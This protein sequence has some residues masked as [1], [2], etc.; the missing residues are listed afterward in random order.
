[1]KPLNMRHLGGIESV[2][3][4]EVS[5]I[6]RQYCIS[7]GQNQVSFIDRE[8]PFY[9]GSTVYST[10]GGSFQWVNSKLHVYICVC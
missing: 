9:E 8:M 4:S 2:L 5:R 7:M 6:L 10:E 1:M 3:Y